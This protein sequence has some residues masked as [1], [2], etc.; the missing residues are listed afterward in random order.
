MRPRF[1]ESF[2]AV[3][4]EHYAAIWRLLWRIVRHDEDTD[5]LTQEAFLS[6]QA[7]FSRLDPG[8]DV[9]TWLRQIAVEH[10]LRSPR[11]KTVRPRRGV[12]EQ[13]FLGLEGSMRAAV[14]LQLEGVTYDDMAR[15]LNIHV[16]TA[17][18]RLLLA[19]TGLL[20]SVFRKRAAHA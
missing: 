19:R 18:S 7:A 9:S 12:V 10:A 14:A 4:H 20:K 11:S 3:V 2:E 8:S 5:R 15:I 16:K 6:A 1:P 17:R 13:G